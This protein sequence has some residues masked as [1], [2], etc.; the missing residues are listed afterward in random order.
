MGQIQQHQVLFN[1]IA[2]GHPETFLEHI[3]HLNRNFAT[4]ADLFA[5]R[6]RTPQEPGS[7]SD[8]V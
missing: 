7:S 8:L 5:G 2:L 1:H 3:P 6:Y 4:P